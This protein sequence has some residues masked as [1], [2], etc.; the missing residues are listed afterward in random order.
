MCRLPNVGSLRLRALTAV[1][2]LLLALLPI[3]TMAAEYLLGSGDVLEISVFGVQE[4]KRRSTIDVDGNISMPLIGEVKASSLTLAEMRAKVKELLASN[5]AIRSSDVLIELAEHRPFFISGDVVRAGAYPF[6]PGMTV[7]HAIALAGGYDNNR[8]KVENPLLM[9][10]DLRGQYEALWADFAKR[11]ARVRRLQAELD[12]KEKVDTSE[13][14]NVPLATNVVEQIT[15]LENDALR[16]RLQNQQREQEHLDRSVDL[17]KGQVENLVAG[18]KNDDASLKIQQ[19]QISRVSELQQKGLTGTNRVLDEQRAAMLMRSRQQENSARIAQ[20]ELTRQDI[21][22]RIE[23]LTDDRRVQL[24]EELQDALVEKAKVAAQLQSTG[25][26]LLYSG[27][28]K[29][30]LSR[31]GQAKS[32]VTIFRM[33][34]GKQVVVPGSEASPVLPDDVVEVITKFDFLVARPNP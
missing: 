24:T 34:D 25:D 2:V 13:L 32:N 29:A 16:L 21:V 6:R 3:R 14:Q 30:E 33:V 22:R 19:E 7:R 28:L 23:R 27:A 15:R 12:G 8:F 20:A 26:K 31:T 9:A 10:T 17:A 4:F 11:D 18:A 1:A 5:D